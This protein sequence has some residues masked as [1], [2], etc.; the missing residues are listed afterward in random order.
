MFMDATFYGGSN[1]TIDGCGRLWRPEISAIYPF[2]PSPF[3]GSSPPPWRPCS[4]TGNKFI[5]G[6]VV[7]GDNWLPVSTTPVINLSPVSTTPTI[8]K[9][10]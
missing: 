9:N 7:T 2:Q 10:Q 6:V 4:V 5:A 8:N 1:D 3:L